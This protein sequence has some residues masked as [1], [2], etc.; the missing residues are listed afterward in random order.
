MTPRYYRWPSLLTI[1]AVLATLFCGWKIGGDYWAGIAFQC[2]AWPF[3]ALGLLGSI[4]TPIA[5]SIVI[6][7]PGQRVFCAKVYIL[8]PKLSVCFIQP[9]FWKY[10][11]KRNYF[12]RY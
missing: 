2:L 8:R 4:A 9:G 1:A 10:C 12:V 5:E 7:T 6:C 11:M 3:M